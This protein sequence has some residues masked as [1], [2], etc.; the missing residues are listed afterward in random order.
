MKERGAM[1]NIFGIRHANTG[2]HEDDDKRQI[3]ELGGRQAQERHRILGGST[4]QDIRFDLVLI[5]PKLRCEQTAQIVI[6]NEALLAE[7]GTTPIIKM[8][9][10]IYAG[11]AMD[12]A[13]DDLFAKYK[14]APLT[15]Y[16]A[17]ERGKYLIPAYGILAAQAVLGQIALHP[18]AKNVLIVGHAICLPAIFW[19]LTQ[20]AYA[21]EQALAVDLE[22]CGCLELNEDCQ[23]NHHS[24][25]VV[26]K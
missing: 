2:K 16:M 15:Q 20:N 25:V 19:A 10:L 23:F 11:G 8:P 21:K 9:E 6:G 7:G 3:T 26:G 22:E 4:G 5:S 24:S 1:P 17:D 12:K 13:I 14:Y 18:E